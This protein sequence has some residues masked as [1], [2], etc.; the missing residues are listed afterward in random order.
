VC[1]LLHKHKYTGEILIQGIISENEIKIYRHS[2]AAKKFTVKLAS[3]NK[4]GSKAMKNLV[5]TS[6][7]AIIALSLAACAS[8]EPSKPK[9][10]AEL[11][12]INANDSQ[13]L[14]IVKL[15]DLDRNIE[16]IKVPED[17][18]VGGYTAAT[19]VVDLTTGALG[20]GV[21]NAA[22]FAGS[23]TNLGVGLLMSNK[24]EPYNWFSFITFAENDADIEKIKQFQTS[25]VKRLGKIESTGFA[26][27]T[28]KHNVY[29]TEKLTGGTCEAS[30]TKTCVIPTGF[31]FKSVV[32]SSEMENL[33][34]K[35]I[36]NK[37]YTIVRW[38]L[39]LS[40]F[41]DLIN[42]G[43]PFKNSY[44]YIPVKSHSVIKYGA[45]ED[46]LTK[47]P[48]LVDLE[49]KTALFFMKM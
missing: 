21:A 35:G 12:P 41:S 37:K 26:N 6:M 16:D 30:S 23:L 42:N 9:T 46:M 24:N 19:G 48:Y 15:A 45:P 3:L 25:Q 2:L 34:I 7:T 5:K 49:S 8:T 39:P 43:I 20:V 36:S 31:W 29:L 17:F 22:G 1:S 38:D 10:L 44:A 27:N 13:A 33:K 18:D 32:S 28:F 47:I 11:T 14:K 40:L 4:R